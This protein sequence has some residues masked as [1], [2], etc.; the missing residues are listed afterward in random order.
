MKARATGERI[1]EATITVRKAG[2]GQQEYLVIK[3]TDVIVTSVALSVAGD[4]AAW[5]GD[6][7]RSSSPRTTS[8]TSR[9]RPT[10]RSMSAS[11]SS[12]T[13]RRTRRASGR[14]GEWRRAGSRRA[15][16]GSSSQRAQQQVPGDHDDAEAGQQDRLPDPVDV[17]AARRRRAVEGVPQVEG[18][19]QEGRA[20]Q[21]RDGHRP[22][23]R[24]ADRDRAGVRQR[25]PE[26]VAKGREPQ[27]GRPVTE[28]ERDD[29]I[30][31]REDQQIGLR[32]GRRDAATA[33]GWTRPP[34][35]IAATPV[36][37]RNATSRI[38]TSSEVRSAAERSPWSA[39]ILRL[40]RERRARPAG[41]S[42]AAPGPATGRTARGGWRRG[43]RRPRRT[44]GSATRSG[45]RPPPRPGGP[46]RR[47]PGA[48]R[49]ASR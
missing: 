43:T 15:R 5:R 38:V 39:W 42:P 27:R 40:D 18:Q 1:K 3:L 29:R 35:T 49:T 13:S 11:I 28:Q 17:A 36:N 10:A 4:D 32:D 41:P 37:P 24:R 25:G 16:R 20:H 7:R 21:A 48:C 12:T 47:A 34:G 33:V 6:H 22:E 8:S 45:R 46:R 9:R 19:R 26:G 14:G 30:A 23:R 44:A 31:G 2:K